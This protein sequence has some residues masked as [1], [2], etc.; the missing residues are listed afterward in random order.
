[1]V[2]VGDEG[3]WRG[4]RC[5]TMSTESRRMDSYH[6]GGK[7]FFCVCLDYELAICSLVSGHFRSLRALNFCFWVGLLLSLFRGRLNFST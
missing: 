2:V 4:T 5:S 6:G 7:L 3:C 1:M